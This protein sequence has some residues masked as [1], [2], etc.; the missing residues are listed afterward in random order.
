MNVD[1]GSEDAGTEVEGRSLADKWILTK[2]AKCRNDVEM[3]IDRY[4][5]DAAAKAL[6]SF[7]WHELCDWYVELIKAGSLGR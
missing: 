3:S 7:V 1:E 4:Q 5:F 6:Y 2:L